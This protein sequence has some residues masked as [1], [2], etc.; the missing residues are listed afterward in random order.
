MIELE[1]MSYRDAVIV[2]DGKYLQMYDGNGNHAWTEELSDAWQCWSRGKVVARIAAKVGGTV[3][4]ASNVHQ[5][6]QGD[7]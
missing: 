5:L 6:L 1:Q 7:E 2:R 4:I 3:M